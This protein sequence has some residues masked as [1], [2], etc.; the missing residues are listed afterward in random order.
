MGWEKDL[1]QKAF[2]DIMSSES[3][4][5]VEDARVEWNTPL[6]NGKV[7]GY[8]QSIPTNDI[9]I[10]K[11]WNEYIKYYNSDTFHLEWVQAAFDGSAITNWDCDLFEPDFG[12]AYYQANP[13]IPEEI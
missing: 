10:S 13:L 12:A 3:C 9:P 7:A 4:Q 11:E 1:E 6:D 5:D 8:L 2:E